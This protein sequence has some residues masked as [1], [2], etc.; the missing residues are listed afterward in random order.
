MAD[1]H[2]PDLAIA[3]VLDEFG[4]DGL[5]A[6]AYAGPKRIAMLRIHHAAENAQTAVH[7]V[8]D[9]IAYAITNPALYRA[10][11]VENARTL[12]SKLRVLADELDK[13]VPVVSL[14]EGEEVAKPE[15][16]GLRRENRTGH[17]DEPDHRPDPAPG[18]WGDVPF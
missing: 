16:R 13:S 1:L 2:Q 10:E 14:R 6:R 8:A 9:V 4:V 5:I 7:W 18:D 15:G 11:V 3:E 12:A 17:P